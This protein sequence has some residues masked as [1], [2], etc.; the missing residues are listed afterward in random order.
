MRRHAGWAAFVGLFTILTATEADAAGVPIIVDTDISSD[1]DDVGAL[2]V[3][4]AL[5]DNGEAEILSVV[6]N[7]RNPVA[8]A[9]VSVINTYYG[10]SDLVIGALKP[11]MQGTPTAY[12]QALVD[13][14]PHALSDGESAPSALSVY[15][16]SLADA[17]DA[18]VVIVSIGLLTNL[19]DLLDSSADDVSELNGKDLVK[20][21]VKKLVVMGGI[22]PSGSE[23]N[24]LNDSVA[25]E[26]VVGNWPTP[27]VYEDAVLGDLISGRPLEQTPATNPV[28]KAYNVYSGGNGRQSW[29]PIAVLYGVRGNAGLFR[30]SEPGRNVISPGGANEWMSAADGH[31]TYLIK[32]A[33]DEQIALELN[34][35][36][37]KSP[38]IM[39]PPASNAGGTGGGVS[40][41]G[42]AS[43]GGVGGGGGT[44]AGKGGTEASAG[45]GGLGGS[46][47]APVS[48]DRSDGGCTITATKERT[49]EWELSALGVALALRL[50]GRRR[51]IV[52]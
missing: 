48:S 21:K 31:E 28:R 37:V 24:F 12:Q 14:F 22:L 2:A 20:A 32:A 39:G 7:T 27:I 9:C 45:N 35:L 44:D 13:G 25:T 46:A 3:M 40:G 18:S 11:H 52:R 1:V 38:G 29:D 34:A 33:S 23:F 50:R 51:A 4:H 6:V 10:R 41:G 30:E 19:R 47:G 42:S 15:R 26:S 16:R 36:M 5:A 43:G 8:A 17:E 49:T